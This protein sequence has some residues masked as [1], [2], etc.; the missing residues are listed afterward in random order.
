MIKVLYIE[1]EESLAMIVKDSLESYGFH[2]HHV[3]NGGQALANHQRYQPDVVLLD[4]MLPLV[5]GFSIATEIRKTDQL[6]PI[7]FL[8]AMTQTDDVVKGFKL[9]GTDYIRKPF[10]IEELIVRIEAC[11]RK[12]TTNSSPSTLTIGLYTLDTIKTTLRHGEH[13]EK[14]SYREMELLKRLIENRDRVVPREEII[15][16]YWSNDA[17]FTGRSLDV[18]I[19]RMR[20]HLAADPRIKIVN[21]RGIGYTLSFEEAQET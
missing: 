8:T 17:F 6:T 19:S 16:T 5:D 20:K 18:F 1:D 12:T 15:R 10:K 21:V 9:G 3:V 7:I 4:I 11:L 2:V 13:V 14:L